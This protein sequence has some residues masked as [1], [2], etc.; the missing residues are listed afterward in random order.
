MFVAPRPIKFSD[1]LLSAEEEGLAIA[2]DFLSKIVGRVDVTYED[3]T[4]SHGSCFLFSSSFYVLTCARVVSKAS[5]LT[6]ILQEFQIPATVF[7]VNEA[8]DIALLHLD[9]SVIGASHH[10]LPYLKLGTQIIPG[11]SI[12]IGGYRMDRYFHVTK[13]SISNAEDLHA[14]K[15][16][17][18]SDNGTSGGPAVGRLYGNLLGIV[19]GGFGASQISTSLIPPSDINL[20]FEEMRNVPDAPTIEFF[21]HF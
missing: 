16:D 7:F 15:A 12:F 10:N 5:A 18:I 17:C 14:I 1:V 2:N 8:L 20:F 19:R 3:G 11:M 6:V 4:S 21:K 9:E 13:G